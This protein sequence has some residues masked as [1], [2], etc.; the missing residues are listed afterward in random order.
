LKYKNKLFAIYLTN[1]IHLVGFLISIYIVGFVSEIGGDQKHTIEE[2][3]IGILMVP[4]IIVIYYLPFL[5]IF[6]GLI[7]L[8]D[9]AFF[10]YETVDQKIIFNLFLESIVIV[11]ISMLWVYEYNVFLWATLSISLFCTQYLRSKKIH[12]I[13]SK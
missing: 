5:I 7:I 11:L 13:I 1:W 2:W 4:L 6:I 8:L 10:Y 3:G 12:Q 9:T